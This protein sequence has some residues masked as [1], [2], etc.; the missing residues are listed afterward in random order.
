M[1]LLRSVVLTLVLSTLAT[2]I[3]VWGGAEYVRARL[4]PPPELHEML[5]SKLQLSGDQQRRFGS[6]E[7]NYA[8]KRESLEAEMRAANAQLARA[9]LEGHAYTPKVQSAIDRFHR[10]M[11]ALQTE[12]MLHVIA[13]RQI[14]T[15]DQA[16][17]FDDTVVKSLTDPAS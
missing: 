3:G 14:L 6:L 15:P 1:T 8:T 7:R 12:T 13:M 5:H 9:Y 2:V 4:R 11:D 10:A 17:Q 16:A